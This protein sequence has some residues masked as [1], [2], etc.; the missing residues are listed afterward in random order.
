MNKAPGPDGFIREFIKKF[1]DI[2]MPD[3]LNAF[4]AI[5][6]DPEQTLKGMNDSYIVLVPKKGALEIKDFRP[7]SL[8]HSMQKCFSKLLANRLQLVM[9]TLIHPSQT[10]F[11]KK[12]H[13][14]ER[15][16]YAQELI[17]MATKER[18]KI[19]LF[20]AD[21][22]KAFDTLSLNFFK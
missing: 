2:L 1:R 15:F 6:V 19:A 14:N 11:L 8:I 3:M 5:L 7:I 4:N 9:D 22:Y 12:R 13:I 16:I 20:K 17:T 21:I 18:A 10:G